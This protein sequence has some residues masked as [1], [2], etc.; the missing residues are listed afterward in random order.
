MTISFIKVRIQYRNAECHIF[1][2]M[3]SVVMLNVVTL[4][5]AHR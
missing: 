1:I 2:A 4:R 3:L 5:V